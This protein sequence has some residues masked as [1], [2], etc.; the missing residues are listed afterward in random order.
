MDSLN[1]YN[2]LKVLTGNSPEELS[3]LINK[4]GV[5]IKIIQIVAAQNRYSAFFLGDVKIK[6]IKSKEVK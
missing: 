2:G 4:I 5:P 3:D 1:P 6:K